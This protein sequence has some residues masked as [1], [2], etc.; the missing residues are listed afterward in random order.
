MKNIPLGEVLKEYGFITEEQLA[1]ALSIQKKETGKRLGAVLIEK[2]FVTE[3]QVLGA[4][5]QK[6]K[7]DVIDLKAYKVDSEQVAK[8][9]KQISSKYNA[10]VVGA[11]NGR[12]ILVMSDP[13]D[14]YARE[15]KI[16]RAHV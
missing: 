13:L 5:G 10:L 12:L 8:L 15:D 2:G 1:E 9:P 6:L 3:G 16:G 11:N 7:C 14:F 4:L